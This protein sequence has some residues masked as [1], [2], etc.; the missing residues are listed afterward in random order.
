MLNQAL[1]ELG[2]LICRTKEPLCLQCPLR[3][4]CEAYKKGIQEII[5]EPKVSV[6]KAIDVSIAVI[7]KGNKFYLQRRPEK[8]LMAGLWEFPGGKIEKGETDK[9]ALIRE[10]KE[11]LNVD[12]DKAKFFL[13]TVH[14]YTQ[15]K[16]NLFVWLVTVK[17]ALGEDDSH[18]WLLLSEI[19]QYPLPSGSAKIVEKLRGRST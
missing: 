14:Y 2:A 9:Q 3:K 4:S 8:G 19:D 13:K 11:E 12:V 1:M 5:P 7:Q 16:V 15:F 6:V 10:V 18:K 17:Q